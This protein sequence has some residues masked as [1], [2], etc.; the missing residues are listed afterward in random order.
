MGNSAGGALS[1]L[2]GANN[3]PTNQI[4]LVKAGFVQVKQ[5]N[6]EWAKRYIMITNRD[7]RYFDKPD[8]DDSTQSDQA[9]NEKSATT[10]IKAYKFTSIMCVQH[11]MSD[12]NAT[13]EKQEN[14]RFVFLK[15]V[16]FFGFYFLLVC[17]CA[18]IFTI[19]VLFMFLLIGVFLFSHLVYFYDGCACE[20]IQ[21]HCYSWC[22]R[23]YKIRT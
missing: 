17:F 20:H 9:S 23:W 10:L 12:S 5:Q 11:T 6:E 22:S 13:N 15:F 4:R 14:N 3:A 1:G 18:R 8:T 21:F 16:W 19:P 7:I 2:T